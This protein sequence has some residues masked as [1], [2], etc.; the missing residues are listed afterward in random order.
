MP[1]PLILPALMQ[2]GAGLIQGG[3]GA[4]GA[5]KARKEAERKVKGMREDQSIVDLYNKA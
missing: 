4:L 1:L 3:F 5:A 2:A